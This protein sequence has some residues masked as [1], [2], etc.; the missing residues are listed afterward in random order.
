MRPT[1]IWLLGALL[2]AG[3]ISVSQRPT[4]KDP[5]TPQRIESPTPPTLEPTELPGIHKAAVGEVLDLY[6]VTESDGDQRWYRW[7]TND[8]FMAFT[9]DGAWFPVDPTEVPA[10]LHAFEPSPGELEDRAV[11]RDQELRELEQQLEEI[12]RRERG[13][14][15]RADELE[16]LDEQ[17]R[18][19]ERKEAEERAR[20]GLP[21]RPSVTSPRDD[22][23]EE[24]PPDAD[25][26]SPD[27]EDA[28]DEDADDDD[29]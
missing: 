8:W 4:E 3:C 23:D 10:D 22:G 24:E 28:D 13:G 1:G 21:P 7:W 25:E 16:D 29:E 27:A 5:K 17:L 6:R 20:K 2:L 26:P 11:S 9:W 15:S 14:K 12:E 18:E 19:I